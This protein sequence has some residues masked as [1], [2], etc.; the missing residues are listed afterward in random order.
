MIKE[1]EI[2][3]HF[4]K[5]L[6]SCKTEHQFLTCEKWALNMNKSIYFTSRLY[7]LAIKKR[8]EF[9]IYK[10]EKKEISQ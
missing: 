8:H 9:R 6:S 3:K 2:I 1:S 10:L 5:V 4:V 7:F